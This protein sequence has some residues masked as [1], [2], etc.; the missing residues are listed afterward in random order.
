MAAGMDDDSTRDAGPPIPSWG[1]AGPVARGAADTGRASSNMNV[2][3]ALSPKDFWAGTFV[4]QAK[5]VQAPHARTVRMGG[6]RR[7]V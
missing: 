4:T 3:G 7:A 1:G 6:G 2:D 5:P